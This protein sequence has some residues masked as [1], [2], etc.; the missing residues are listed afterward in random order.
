MMVRTAILSTA[1]FLIVCAFG[2][3]AA[4][5]IVAGVAQKVLEDAEATEGRAGSTE[6]GR[7]AMRAL[8]IGNRFRLAAPVR[9]ADHPAAATR[10]VLSLRALGGEG[11]SAAGW[12]AEGEPRLALPVTASIWVDLGYR[13]ITNEDLAAAAFVAAERGSLEPDYVSHSVTI[14]ARWQF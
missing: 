2:E 9:E 1:A 12:A 8:R 3:A 14:H 5:P 11:G 13:L 6:A 10:P 4:T 7:G